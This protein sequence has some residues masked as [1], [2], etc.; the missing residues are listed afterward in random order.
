MATIKE[1]ARRAG[2]SVGT[3][4]NVLSGAPTVAGDL[5]QRVEA[6][7]RDLNYHP[8]HLAR[9]LKSQRSHTIGMIV[10]DISNPFFPLVIRG[11]EAAAREQGYVLTI[12]NTDDELER[13]RQIFS[14]LRARRVDGILAVVAP[15]PERDT[16]HLSGAVEAGIA[17]VCLDR[18][19]PGFRTDTVIVD[20]F[21]GA[22]ICVRHL[23]SLGHRAIGFVSG[24][25]L[26]QTA[27]E[28]RRGYAK[29][30]L[31]AGIRVNKSLIREGDFRIESGYRLGKDLLLSHPRPT[32]IFAANGTMGLGVLKAIQELCLRCPEDA[33]LAVFDEVPSAEIL[34]PHLTSVTQP[35]YQIGYKA[36]ELLIARL[37]GKLTSD[38][39]LTVFEPELRV[40]E[41]TITAQAG[42]PRE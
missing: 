40:R 6:V 25:S 8:N 16:A 20:N 7:I 13:E 15:N 42:I 41:S 39:V 9:S 32:A 35:S 14:V 33:A 12:F 26:L 17:V 27:Q 30:L 34:R 1:V 38:P 22:A 2:V 5:R 4:S 31:E 21:K 24:S 37:S 28:R 10:S 36:T 11:A 3:V 18:I 23:I 29:A 19:P